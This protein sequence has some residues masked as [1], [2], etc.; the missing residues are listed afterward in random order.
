MLRNIDK[1]KDK[2]R[3]QGDK[4]LRKWRRCDGHLNHNEEH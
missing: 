1:R 2:R 4:T 3:E